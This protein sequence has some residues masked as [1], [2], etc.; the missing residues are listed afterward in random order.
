V[1]ASETISKDF[2][3]PGEVP[4]ATCLTGHYNV[5]TATGTDPL[6][7]TVSDD[8]D[9]CTDLADPKIEVV[10]DGP[11]M[12]HAGDTATFTFKVTNVGDVPLTGVAVVDSEFGPVGTIAGTL[13][14]GDFQTISKDFAVPGKVPGINC[15]DGHYNVATASGTDALGK[16]VEDSDDHCVTIIDP[17]IE[18]EKSAPGQVHAGDTVTYTFKVTNTGDVDLVDVAVVDD[19][20]GAVGTIASLVVGESKTIS[21]DFVVPGVNSGPDCDEGHYN[22]ATATGVDPLQ[23]TVSDTDDHCA[24]IIDPA[25]EVEKTGEALAHEGDVVTYNFKVTNIGDV[26]L[27]DV[28]V[29]DD[30]MGDIG[31]VPGTLGVGDSATLSKDFTVPENTD[32][33]DNIATACGDDPTDLE[34]CDDDPHSMI[35]IHPS[36]QIVKTA[37]PDSLNPGQTVTFTYVVTNIGDTE[38]TDIAVTD[39]VLGDI[40]T[41]DSLQPGESATLTKDQVVAD[42]SPRT[43][44]GT[45]CGEDQLGLVVCD[46]EDATITIV[47]PAGPEPRLPTT[48][49]RMLFLMAL[50]TALIGAGMAMRETVAKWKQQLAS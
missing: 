11:G 33:V 41:I 7:K 12:L 24:E 19:E 6:G 15:D 30:I 1:G 28:T 36:I 47:L 26:E 10:K 8:D 49:A 35:V 18:V 38:L 25:I 50:A 13:G 44:I 9:H 27:V 32:R 39:D 3:V 48:G 2:A 46:D 42:D 37:S 34:V 14:V 4:A 16:T 21:K 22:V 23:D 45:A 40:G 20:F 17:S 31:T 5:A 43:N 29:T